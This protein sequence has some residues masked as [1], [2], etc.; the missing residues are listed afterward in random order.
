[1]IDRR[2]CGDIDDGSAPLLQHR[3]YRRT[4]QRVARSQ[5]QRQHLVED[6][7]LQLPQLCAAG[8]ATD[9]VDHGV[10]TAMLPHNFLD[11][12]AGSSFIRNI[13]HMP[14]QIRL[15]FSRGAL[16]AIEFLPHTIGNNNSCVSFKE[17][18]RDGAPQFAGAPRH[19]DYFP[20][21]F[22]THEHCLKLF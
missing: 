15:V 8:V 1:M 9:G 3:S 12:L 16:Q 5:I 7:R 18:P 22:R 14:F 4:R 13:N 11:Q 20:I 21:E 6:F 19:Q 2:F 17:C 10:Q